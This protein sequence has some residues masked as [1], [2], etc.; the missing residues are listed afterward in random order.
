MLD[1]DKTCALLFFS[2]SLS[3]TS[4]SFP[5][6]FP[7][8]LW[9]GCA[10]RFLHEEMRDQGNSRSSRE[11]GYLSPQCF[12]NSDIFRLA[13]KVL[14]VT[15]VLSSIVLFRGSKGKILLCRRSADSV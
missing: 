14:S 1:N 11:G 15:N 4:S 3:G 13:L 12:V 7:H 10:E 2:F 8:E 9:M 5:L 6:G